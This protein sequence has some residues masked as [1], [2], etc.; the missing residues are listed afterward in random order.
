MKKV[1][2]V[3]TKGINRR[4]PKEQSAPDRLHTLQ[5]A[6]IYQKGQTLY[7]TRI[8]GSGDWPIIEDTNP[9]AV[10]AFPA[11]FDTTGYQRGIRLRINQ[12]LIVDDLTPKVFGENVLM[13]EE[14]WFNTRPTV[15]RFGESVDTQDTNV[16]RMRPVLRFIESQEI[17]DNQ[18]NRNL[19]KL[20]F[21]E[22]VSTS[23]TPI[24]EIVI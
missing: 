5:N 15:L 23:D 10:I 3:F 16:G 24:K 11:S 4:I 2:Q 6:R 13:G 7:V 14:F 8:Q 21:T 20:S 19:I 22:G 18:T 9:L 1:Q 12:F 17:D